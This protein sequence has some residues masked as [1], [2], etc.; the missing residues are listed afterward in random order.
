MPAYYLQLPFAA[1]LG[2]LAFGEVPGA[3]IWVGAAIIC[4]ATYYIVRVE[5]A[6]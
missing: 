4:G 3:W 6:S 5:S 1:L 2:Y